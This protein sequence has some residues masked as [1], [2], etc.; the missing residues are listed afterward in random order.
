[1][2]TKINCFT[3]HPEEVG[4]TYFQHFRFAINLAQY[5]FRAC[6]AS[7]IHAVFPFAFVTTTSKITFTLFN[8][9]KTRIP[10]EDLGSAGKNTETD[11]RY[12]GIIR[13]T[14]S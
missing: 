11:L 4:M 1:M 9:L 14:G 6:I 5:S 7:L 10:T 3:K 8:K 12:I 2:A 13:E